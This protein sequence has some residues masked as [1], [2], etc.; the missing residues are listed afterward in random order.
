ML[1]FILKIKWPI[2]WHLLEKLGT[3]THC[4]W[5]NP[6]PL[7]KIFIAWESVLVYP[8][9]LRNKEREWPVTTII[10]KKQNFE[11]AF[12]ILK[13]TQQQRPKFL[14]WFTDSFSNLNF[15]CCCTSSKGGRSSFEIKA[16]AAICSLLFSQVFFKSLWK[17]FLSSMIL[18]KFP[19][20]LFHRNH[21]IK[22]SFLFVLKLYKTEPKTALI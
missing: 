3:K 1:V 20:S 14:T 18:R 6:V 17:S 2:A 7:V 5:E 13:L 22:I 21:T 15:V 12:R 8:N 9:I 4:S 16:C 10:I 11:T 19:V